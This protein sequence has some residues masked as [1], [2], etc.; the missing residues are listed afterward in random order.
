[1]LAVVDK[2]AGCALDMGI[3]SSD[4]VPPRRAVAKARSVTQL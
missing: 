4:V 3:T 2:N 1:M